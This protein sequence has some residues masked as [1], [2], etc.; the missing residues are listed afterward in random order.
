MHTWLFPVHILKLVLFCM[1]PM[2]LFLCFFSSV[3]LSTDS[4]FLYEGKLLSLIVSSV[5][6]A[7][8]T[9]MGTVIVKSPFKSPRQGRIRALP[10]IVV[11]IKR[12]P[13]HGWTLWCLGPVIPPLPYFLLYSLCIAKRSIFP[14]LQPISYILCQTFST[15][16]S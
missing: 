16:Y 2:S 3:F 15:L 11:L 9:V 12:P 8:R 7:S 13:W 1:L 6:S 10:L 5:T 14:H 4:S